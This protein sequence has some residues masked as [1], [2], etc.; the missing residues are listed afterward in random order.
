MSWKAGYPFVHETSC[1]NCLFAIWIVD[2][3]VTFCFCFGPSLIVAEE[4]IEKSH[5]L[6]LLLCTI[7]C[8]IVCG[9]LTLIVL[10]MQYG[11]DTS[12]FTY[13]PSESHR[14]QQVNPQPT[15]ERS[16]CAIMWSLCIA[17]KLQ[18]IEFQWLFLWEMVLRLS[19]SE[20]TILHS[21]C[22]IHTLLDLLHFFFHDMAAT[23]SFCC[24]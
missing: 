17:P 2:L 6:L 22:I 5:T 1:N 12:E 4:I 11:L 9:H 16:R 23:S 8:E 3:L 20:N 19:L 13:N 24:A 7:Y 21:L 18:Q 14:Y 15:E 10:L